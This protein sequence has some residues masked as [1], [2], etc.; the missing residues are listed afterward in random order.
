[1]LP[2][3]WRD[4]E[5]AVLLESLLLKTRGNIVGRSLIASARA[6]TNNWLVYS[7]NRHAKGYPASANAVGRGASIG[8]DE[9]TVT[10]STLG[11]L[12]I[13]FYHGADDVASHRTLG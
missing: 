13:E 2:V 6:P 3:L 1:M 8:C 11:I 9:H 7:R 4:L 10:V 12:G 5:L